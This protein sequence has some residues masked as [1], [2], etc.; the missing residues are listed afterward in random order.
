MQTCTILTRSTL[1]VILLW[2]DSAV[3][4]ELPPA[5]TCHTVVEARHR[6]SG[7]VLH[8]I[9]EGAACIDPSPSNALL[10]C[11]PLRHL[12]LCTDRPTPPPPPQCCPAPSATRLGAAPRRP[13]RRRRSQSCLLPNQGRPWRPDQKQRP[14]VKMPKSGI[15][16]SGANVSRADSRLFRQSINQPFGSNVNPG[17]GPSKTVGLRHV[18]DS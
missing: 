10:P 12:L 7:L 16:R 4:N 11:T 9:P 17:R 8:R 1:L 2:T 13:R 14:P 6:L 3:L 15:A 18:L 5:A